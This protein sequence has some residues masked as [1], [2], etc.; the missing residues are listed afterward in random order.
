MKHLR[1]EATP[2]QTFYDDLEASIKRACDDAGPDVK[3]GVTASLAICTKAK[4]RLHDAIRAANRRHGI[5]HAE[6]VLVRDL[7]P[8]LQA[9]NDQYKY[10]ERRIREIEEVQSRIVVRPDGKTIILPRGHSFAGFTEDGKVISG[11]T[12]V[13][14]HTPTEQPDRWKDAAAVSASRA[15]RLRCQVR[16]RRGLSGRPRASAARSSVQ[17]GDS[18][19]SDPESEPPRRRGQLRHVSFALTAFLRAMGGAR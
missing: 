10:V 16:Q 9:L 3:A 5:D 15:V 14:I 1:P 12:S 13:E 4:Q 2:Q 6:R 17:S 7:P 18:G 8:D 19:D 11:S